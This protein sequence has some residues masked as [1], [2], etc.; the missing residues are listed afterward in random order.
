MTLLTSAP[1]DSGLAN[2]CISVN[3]VGIQMPAPIKSCRS[4]TDVA[5]QAAGI[6]PET[7]R[8]NPSTSTKV[9]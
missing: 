6:I 8:I 3:C 7:L 9:T 1:R 5:S 2:C 4:Q